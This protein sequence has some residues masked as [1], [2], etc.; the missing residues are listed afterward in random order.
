M[1]MIFG[2]DSYLYAARVVYEP[3]FVFAV[4]L[5]TAPLPVARRIRQVRSMGIG[6]GKMRNYQAIE[7]GQEYA[8][9]AVKVHSYDLSDRNRR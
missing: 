7:Y 8:Y 5:L 3:G 9:F 6:F 4:L 2:D 1:L